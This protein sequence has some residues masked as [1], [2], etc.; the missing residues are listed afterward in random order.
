MWMVFN[1]SGHWEHWQCL[2]AWR[3]VNA[4]ARLDRE[5]LPARHAG[6]WGNGTCQPAGTASPALIV[7]DAVAG[8]RREAAADLG[9]LAMMIMVM[10]RIRCVCGARPLPY[11]GP[12]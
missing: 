12:A 11:G 2:F 8:E 6:G 3:R 10:R 9:G 4:M 5:R 1:A 7:Q